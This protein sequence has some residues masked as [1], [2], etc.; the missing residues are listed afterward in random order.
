[1]SIRTRIGQLLRGELRLHMF[2]L[3]DFDRQLDSVFTGAPTASGVAVSEESS[4]ENTAVWNAITLI[5]QTLAEVPLKLF[6]RVTPRGK[7][8]ARANPLFDILHSAP[9]PEMTSF[10]WRESQ[11]G[12]LLGWGNA[13][14]EIVFN[15]RT[16]RIDA[17]WPIPWSRIKVKRIE[18]QI[19]YDILIPDTGLTVT[20]PAFRVLH[21]RGFSR[22]GIVGLSPIALHRQAVALGLAT[23]QYGASFFGNG[24][25]PGGVLRHPQ[26]LSKEAQARLREAWTETQAGLSNAQRVAV[27]EEGLE[28]VKVGIDPEDAQFLATRVFQVEEVA[29]IFNIPPS[30]IGELSKAT[31][32]NVTEQSINFVRFTMLPW[33]FRWEQ[34][35]DKKL[36]GPNERQSLFIKFVVEALLR[37]TPKERGDFYNSMFAVGAFSPNDI[38]DKEDMN[39]IEGGDQYFKPLNFESLTAPTED[40]EGT[41][42]GTT[43]E[44]NSRLLQLPM[45]DRLRQAFLPSFEDL[46]VRLIRAER[47]EMLKHEAKPGFGTWRR[48]Y[49]ETELAKLVKKQSAGHLRTYMEAIAAV[50]LEDSGQPAE[51]S[52]ELSRH[53]DIETD[54]FVTRYVD[55]AVYLGGDLTEH[56]DRKENESSIAVDETKL[57]GD[58]VASHVATSV[59]LLIGGEK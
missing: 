46:V 27:L 28:Y 56:Y 4:L 13:A 59:G 50:A 57:L 1:M 48:T 16:G 42:G 47:R 44:E 36:L 29:R 53:I 32:S 15:Q 10:E 33:F 34:G 37:G 3:A 52:P 58:S 18:G 54:G 30:M 25:V 41:A 38:R 39:P 21:I 31:F 26:T 20:L 51:I 8:E 45:K 19:F 11:M 55:D 7:I 49:Y 2:S 17:L 35:M 23:E 24:A 9:N 22:D 12:W 43:L 6:Q 40:D 5:S 14:S